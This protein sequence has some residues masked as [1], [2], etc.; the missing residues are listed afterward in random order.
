MISLLAV[1]TVNQLS[2]FKSLID[3]IDYPIKKLSV[4]CNSYSF[5]YLVEIRKLCANDFVNEFI[6]SHCPYNMGCSMSWNYHIKMNPECDNWIF[7]GD[8]MTF[9]GGDLKSAH[10]ASKNFDAAFS[11][12]PAKYSFFSLSKSCVEKVGFFDENIH[13]ACFEDDDYDRRLQYHSVS[14]GSFQFNG[15]HFG[16][17]TTSNLSNENKEK[18]KNFFS[19]NQNYFHKKSSSGDFGQGVFDFNERSKKLLKIK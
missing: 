2:S 8:D 15:T 17:G 19:M 3:S 9:S 16:S 4:L 12:L 11:S 7:S 10:K 14:T 6:V 5:E 18:M 1:T 13:P